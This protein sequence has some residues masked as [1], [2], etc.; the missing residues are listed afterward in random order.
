MVRIAAPRTEPAHLGRWAG[1]EAPIVI[2]H[3]AGEALS[4]VAD[5]V[6][7]D[8]T[9]QVSR[10]KQGIGRIPGQVAKIGQTELAVADHHADRLPVLGIIVA[11]PLE[12]GAGRT[13]EGVTVRERPGD[14]LASAAHHV[15]VQALDGHAV[16]RLDDN[17]L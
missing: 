1:R 14:D 10:A 13:R 16:A 15:D 3:A 9:D 5:D 6:G 11:P 7:V 8:R 17:V 4:V 12:S 2:A